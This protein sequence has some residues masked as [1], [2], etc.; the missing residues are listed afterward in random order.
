MTTRARSHSSQSMVNFSFVNCCPV[1]ACQRPRMLYYRSMWQA[2]LPNF[3]SH[4]RL[5]VMKVL[6]TGG[7]Q[8]P[9]GV[10]GERPDDNDDE[11]PLACNTKTHESFISAWLWIVTSRGWT[12]LWYYSSWMSTRW[13]SRFKILQLTW[14]RQFIISR[15]FHN[16]C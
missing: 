6:L 15:R 1:P 2:N 16:W 5:K 11:R 14:S 3:I 12:T 13:P 4:V 10:C 9:W 7:N 8:W